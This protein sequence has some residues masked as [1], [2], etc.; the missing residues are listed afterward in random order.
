MIPLLAS[1]L[2][3]RMRSSMHL[4]CF[5]DSKG[6]KA[7]DPRLG[8][9]IYAYQRSPATSDSDL[10]L[11]PALDLSFSSMR[12]NAMEIASLL[13]ISWARDAAYNTHGRLAGSTF[14]YIPERKC[15]GTGTIDSVKVC[16]RGVAM[17]LKSLTAHALDSWPVETRCCGGGE[18]AFK[19]AVP[20][21]T[22][23]E[24]H[25]RRTSNS[26]LSIRY[27]YALLSP[28]HTPPGI[29]PGYLAT[30]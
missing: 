23:S 5:N 9:S 28:R 27:N 10:E 17:T 13:P 29:L 26:P 12:R 11:R 16:R 25:R 6:N 22:A 20:D 2:P 18:R 30:L 24:A 7:K 15:P 3:Q 14:A 1:L 8:L 4:R 21:R 19:K